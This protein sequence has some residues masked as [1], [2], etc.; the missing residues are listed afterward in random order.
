MV[1]NVRLEYGG[2]FYHI[3][4]RGNRRQPIF[5]ADE[6]LH[7]W[8]AALAEACGRTDWLVTAWV[9]LDDHHYLVLETLEPKLVA[10]MKWWQNAPVQRCQSLVSRC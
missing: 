7:F 4:A 10:R 6:D 5:Y 1:R 2:A 9:L 8:L 3:M